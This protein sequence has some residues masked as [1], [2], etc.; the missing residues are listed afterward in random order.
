MHFILILKHLVFNSVQGHS[1]S[2]TRSLFIYTAEDNNINWNLSTNVSWLTPSTTSGVTEGTIQV[3]VNTNGLTAG[4]HNGNIT[5]SSTQPVADPITV[6][7][8]LIINPDVPVTAT[9]W[10]DGKDGA[11]SV[12]VDDGESSG[13]SVLQS[14]G[15]QGTYVSNGTSPPPFYPQYYNAGME[16]GSHLVNHPCYYVTD[17]VLRYQEIEPNIAGIC[18]NTPQ[19]CQNLITMVWPCGT[20]N[21]REQ[22]IA[23]EYFLSARG[24]NINQLEDATPENF[25]N[26]KSYNS[27]EHTPYPPSDLKTVVDL[28]ISQR[29]WFNLVLHTQTNDDG[30]TI[31]AST[32]N[33]WGTSIGNVIKYILQ[34]DRFILTNYSASSDRITFNASRLAIPPS[35]SKN[36]ELAFG[37]N[38]ITTIQ[39]DIDDS[40]TIGNV[41]VNSVVNP[42]HIIDISGN[43]VLLTDIRLEP[44]VNKAVEVTYQGVSSPLI[45]LTPNTLSFNAIRNGALPASQ[46]VSITNTGSSDILNWTSSEN[47]SWL[48]VSPQSGTTPGNLTVT[49]DQTGLDAGIYNGSITISSSGVSNSPQTVN[50]SLTVNSEGA[51]NLHYD[52]AYANR[53]SL[54]ADGWDFLAVTSTGGSRN[55][56]QTSGYVVSYD[57]VA[58]PG[59]LRIPVDVGDLWNGLNNT[60]NSLFRNLP[61]N[62][63]SARIRI[64]SFAPSQNYQQAGLVAYQDDNNYVQITRIYEGGNNV[65]FV[66][67]TGGNASILNAVSQGATTDLYFRLD[68][69]ISTGAIS[70]FYSL[71]GSTWTSMGSITQTLNNP[72]LGIVVGASPG[73]Y[74]NADI[75]WAEVYVASSTPALNISPANLAF[76]GVINGTLPASQNVSITNSGTSEILNWTATENISWLSVSPQSGTTPGNLTVSADQ[77]GLDAGTYNGTVTISSTGVSNSPRTVNVSLTVNSEGTG[78]L[79]Y[80]FT[81]ANRTGLLADGWDFIG[82]TSAGGSRN[83]EQTSGYV[84]SYDQVAHPGVLRIPVDVGDLWEGLNNTRNSLFRNLPSNWTSARLSIAS[85]APT[86]NYQQ[87]G[88]V[89]YQDDNNYVQITRIYEGGNY[90]TFVRETGGT[91]SIL[92]SVSQSATTNLYFRLDRNI[93]TGSITSYYS[94]NGTTWTTVGSVTQTL[95]NPR[96]AIVVG[97]SPSGYPNADIAW[98]E[99]YTSTAKSDGSGI[100]LQNT[101][102]EVPA[103]LPETE[104]KL[105]QNYPNPFNTT[106]W[107]EYDLAEDA[108]VILELYNSFGQKIET[109]Q[110]QNMSSGN[111]KISWDSSNY[112][113]GIYYLTM[114]TG[115]F[116]STIKMSILK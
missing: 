49:V 89:A 79:H 63:T 56:E 76:T 68:R 31:Y 32:R 28:A 66:R 70:A 48:S 71:N 59:V 80:D 86:R 108:H 88:L 109:V 46:S 17:D 25:M 77:T 99:I 111:H 29:R 84:V 3:G 54:L 4:L 37:S 94:L 50:V 67:E 81:Y 74:P 83:T 40:R 19:P 13:F 47:I 5:I 65:T 2:D 101:K 93:T 23:S 18:N 41:L 42:Y 110:N 51:D 14:S 73:G 34:R 69:N 96:L 105:H 20:T 43:N 91:A 27:H 116:R 15:F 61:S 35:A 114:K 85:F 36:F 1:I 78:N 44:G 107:I 95:N 9:T 22:A 16:L 106:T 98:A 103:V 58:H 113:S 55:T 97:A 33:I 82:V 72:R 64:A 39:V 30:A 90:M 52:F 115:I 12:C 7:V 100:T 60:R 10:K 87:A 57:Q 104:T 38:D 112:P 75:A 6:P 92:N 21:D 45:S 102:P 24:Y 11:M 26:L 53:T 8:T 62:W